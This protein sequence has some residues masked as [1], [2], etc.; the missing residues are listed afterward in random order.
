MESIESQDHGCSDAGWGGGTGPV[1]SGVTGAQTPPRPS[2]PVIDRH[3]YA[4]RGCGYRAL[5]ELSP[6]WAQALLGGEQ[7]ALVGGTAFGDRVLPL[8]GRGGPLSSRQP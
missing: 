3:A 5:A 8:I 6:M 2:G 7:L 1:V 4:R